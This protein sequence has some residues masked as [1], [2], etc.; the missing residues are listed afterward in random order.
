MSLRITVL[1]ENT[2]PQGGKTVGEHGFSALIERDGDRIL[3]DTGQGI[4]LCANARA[5][6]IDLSNV[7][8][9]VISH[10]HYDHTG[11]LKDFLVQTEGKGAEILCHPDVFEAKYGRVGDN[12]RY[13]GIPFAAEAIRGWGGVL[14]VSTDPVEVRSGVW[15]TGEVLRRNPSE[16]KDRRL[17]VRRGDVFEEDSLLDDLS[18]VI[19][20]PSGLVV[21]LGCAHAGVI[22]TLSHI[23]AMTG[24]SAFHWVVGGTHLGFYEPA[25]LETVTAH[26]RDLRIDH[27][28][29][30]H[31]TGLRAGARLAQ[32]VGGALQFCNVGSVIEVGV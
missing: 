31:C 28:G 25:V 12:L 21:I 10:G 22:N 14:R 15:T 23:Q 27:L 4:G 8:T 26:L 19:D 20:T 1:C 9:V 32:E 2:V 30:S 3:F 7:S 17:L 16:A 24:K 13:I 6:G 5:L 18:L 29:V 11:G